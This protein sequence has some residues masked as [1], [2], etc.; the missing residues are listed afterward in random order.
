MKKIISVIGAGTMGTG[1]AQ[2]AAT[3][4]CTVN[5]IDNSRDVLDSSKSNLHSIFNRLVEKG[6]INEVESANILLKI[7][8]S[9][10]MEDIAESELVIE[11]VIEN[12]EVKQ[13]IFSQ[14]E[15]VVSNVC[16]FISAF[17]LSAPCDD[18]NPQPWS[19]F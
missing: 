8:F 6:K 3:H 5:L 1:I 9:I 10:E 14:I 13:K 19:V 2:V 18:C 15:T 16:F 7:N 12:M 17:L 11:A 4:G